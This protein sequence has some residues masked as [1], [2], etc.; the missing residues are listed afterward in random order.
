MGKRNKILNAAESLLA[1]RGFHGLSMKLL[2]ETAGIAAGT[3]YRYFDNKEELM[4]ELHQYINLEVSQTI[5]NGWLENQTAQHK[6]NLL[7]RN[8]FD[9]VLKN[10]QRLVIDIENT[11]KNFDFSK[12]INESKLVNKVRYSSAKNP[13]SVRIVIELNKKLEKIGQYKV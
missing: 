12:I 2:A 10:P 5:F 11:P 4:S 13:Q 1:E 6:Y 3:I 9:G 8:T 7:W